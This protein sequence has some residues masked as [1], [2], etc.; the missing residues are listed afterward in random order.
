[1]TTLD[2]STLVSVALSNLD[3]VCHGLLTRLSDLAAD[4]FAFVL[5]AL[6]LVRV[7]LAQLADVGRNL[8]DLL[9]VDAL[10]RETSG[11]STLK[12][13]PSGASTVIEWL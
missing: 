13:M 10:D 3:T 2:G 9:L 8:A 5:D 7:G 1:M 11:A 12:V 6:G 4:D